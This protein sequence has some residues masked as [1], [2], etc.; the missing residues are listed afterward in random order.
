MISRCLPFLISFAFV[1]SDVFG[2]LCCL[3]EC[4]IFCDDFRF[5]LKVA[6]YCPVF[7]VIKSANIFDNNPC[8]FW[9]SF[10]GNVWVLAAHVFL[11]VS[12]GSVRRASRHCFWLFAFLCSK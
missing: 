8:V 4:F 7:F 3:F 10:N 6:V 1:G 12:A 2:F 5:S 11:L 9:A